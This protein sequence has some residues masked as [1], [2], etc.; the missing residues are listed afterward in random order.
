MRTVSK[1][2][3]EQVEKRWIREEERVLPPIILY[4]KKKKNRVIE[5]DVFG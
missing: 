4:K 2:T 1:A 3:G 5:Q